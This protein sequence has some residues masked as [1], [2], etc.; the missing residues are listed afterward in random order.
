[1]TASSE[2]ATIGVLFVCLGNICRSPLAKGVLLHLIRARGLE[3]RFRVD[4]CGTSGWHAGDPADPR[5]IAV[6]LKNG[7]RFEHAARPLRPPT[8]F[9]EFDWLLAMDLSNVQNLLRAGAPAERVRLLRSFDP[10]LA[11]LPEGSMQVPDPYYGGEN[12]FDQNFEM[13]HRACEGLIRT[14]TGP[15][16]DGSG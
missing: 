15:R 4:S 3:D 7:I 12:G 2:P 8:D 6:G 5:T 1:M 16:S 9:T 10:T 13:I 14:L 11:G